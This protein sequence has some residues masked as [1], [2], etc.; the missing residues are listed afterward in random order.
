M[1]KPPNYIT[2]TTELTVLP[3][4]E[5]IFSEMATIIRIEDEAAGEFVKIKQQSG[6]VDADGQAITVSREEWPAIKQAVETLLAEIH[7]QSVKGEARADNA[8]SPK[9]TDSITI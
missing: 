5:P 2:R 1:N 9:G 3:E 7:G 6:H 8:T 4:G